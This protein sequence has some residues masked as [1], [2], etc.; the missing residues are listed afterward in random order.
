MRIAMI[1]DVGV[2]DGMM[3]IGDEAMFE[4]MVAALRDRGVDAITAI[5]AAP[6]DT[7]TRYGV[8]AIG[9]IGFTGTR[10]QMRER[11]EAVRAAAGGAP[12]LADRDPA[13]A[14]VDAVADADAVVIAGGGNLASNWPSHV[15]ERAALGAIADRLGR[16]LVVS[17]QTLGPWL[18]PPDRRLVA[19]LLRSARLTGV[20]E[21]AS[22][23]LAG[24]L[25]VPEDRLTGNRDDASFLGIGDPRSASGIESDIERG[26]AERY[27]LVSLSLHLGGLPRDETVRG[28]ASALDRVAERADAPVR[29][30]P[31]FGSLD[32]EIEAGD[33]VLHAAVLDAMR[34]PAELLQPGDARSAA[35][36]AR[37]AAML[38]TSRY[39]PAVFATAAGV[40]V[41]ALSADDYTAVKLRGATGW[42]G[43]DGVIP[44][45]LAASD[46]GGDALGDVWDRRA[47][48]R[49]T[50][51]A[52]RS[53]A[54]AESD[55]WF[56][57]VARALAG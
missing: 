30:H 48:T 15:F 39:H 44:L 55:G 18:D 36:L 32:P 38:V 26:A 57:R 40:P 22:L 29:F 19:E 6:A 12:N 27:V 50:A 10:E 11:L 16:P 56:D 54:M 17:G 4:A 35:R 1:G 42:W 31:H 9:R 46:R 53:R 24:E 5:S 49:R 33:E 14:V 13:A 43:Q 47:T 21:P 37:G 51:S 41:A 52:L 7:A 3:H 45:G 2:V 20:R 34:S 28:L 25:G 8:A 23:A